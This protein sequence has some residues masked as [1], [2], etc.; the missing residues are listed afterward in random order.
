MLHGGGTTA[1]NFIPLISALQKEYHFLVPD[2]PA[3][4]HWIFTLSPE[5]KRLVVKK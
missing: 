1:A 2:R 4:G 3:C 5:E